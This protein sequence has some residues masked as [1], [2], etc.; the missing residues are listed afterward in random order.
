[1]AVY[2]SY[3]LSRSSSSCRFYLLYKLCTLWSEIYAGFFDF[4]PARSTKSGRKQQQLVVVFTDGA[5]QN[6][7]CHT[8]Y[9]ELKCREVVL[10]E[11][12]ER[13]WCKLQGEGLKTAEGAAAG[14][15]VRADIWDHGSVGS[16][17]IVSV[18]LQTCNAWFVAFQV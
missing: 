8:D 16:A 6:L 17:C 10:R 18:V 3:I 7:G 4:C 2:Y 5:V 15:N 1:M 11:T 14:Q 9:R 13:F 12:P